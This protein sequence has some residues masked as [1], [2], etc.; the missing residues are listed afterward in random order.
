MYIY[1]I[2]IVQPHNSIHIHLVHSIYSERKMSM[3]QY[4]LLRMNIYIM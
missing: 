1:V 2:E 3:V 4:T